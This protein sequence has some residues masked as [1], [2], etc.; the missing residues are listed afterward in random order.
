MSLYFFNRIMLFVLVVGLVTIYT[1]ARI[2]E[3][4]RQVV[5]WLPQTQAVTLVP[6]LGAQIIEVGIKRDGVVVWR[7]KQ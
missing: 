4:K 1:A 3:E 2:R 6:G 5:N 7:L